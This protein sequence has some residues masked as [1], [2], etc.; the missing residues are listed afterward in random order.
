MIIVDTDLQSAEETQIEEI[1][2][3]SET[4][5]DKVMGELEK[6][7]DGNQ[8]ANQDQGLNQGQVMEL[9]RNVHAPH[10]RTKFLEVKDPKVPALL[11][12]AANWQSDFQNSRAS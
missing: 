4:R 9:I 1:I 12:I 2:K 11:Q 8:A 6:V 5:R 10:L 7:L 3:A